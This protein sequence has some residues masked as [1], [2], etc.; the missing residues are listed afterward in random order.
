M[1]TVKKATAKGVAKAVLSFDTAAVVKR[2]LAEAPERAR[3]VLIRRFGLGAS[4]ER[5][6]LEAIGDRSGITRERVRQ[7]ESKALRKLRHPTRS[8]RIKQFLDM[9]AK[10][11]Q[12]I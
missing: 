1:N 8:R 12:I 11:D 5:E 3:D 4:P 7:I 10:E 9:A 2:L 6:T